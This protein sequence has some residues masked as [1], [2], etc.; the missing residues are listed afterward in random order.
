[1]CTCEISQWQLDIPNSLT[2]SVLQNFSHTDQEI[3]CLD[4]WKNKACQPFLSIYRRQCFGHFFTTFYL[5]PFDFLFV[6]PTWHVYPPNFHSIGMS[7]PYLYSNMW[8]YFARYLPII[9]AKH[10][11]SNNLYSHPANSPTLQNKGPS[12]SVTV[13]QDVGRE[14]VFI[15]PCASE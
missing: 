12:I 7:V 15:T 8:A 5:Y 2:L 13:G 9:Y 1:M 4:N 10:I 11:D 3:I 6:P 14:G